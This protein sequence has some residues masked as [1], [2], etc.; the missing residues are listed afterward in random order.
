VVAAPRHWRLALA[1]LSMTRALRAAPTPDETAVSTAQPTTLDGGRDV[2]GPVGERERQAEARRLRAL[3]FWDLRS[4]P[5]AK[6]ELLAAYELSPRPL[7]L[8]NLAVTS[9]ALGD[10]AGAYEYFES[11]L[12]QGGDSITAERR[13]MVERQLQDLAE[14]V[15]ALHVSAD[16]VGAQVLLDDKLVGTTPLRRALRLNVGDHSVTVRRGASSQETLRISVRGGQALPLH[17]ALLAREQHRA[18][19]TKR[20]RWLIASWTGTALLG[21]GAALAGW[22]A[23]VAN[24]DY[25]K[26][27]RELD[28]SRKQ[29]DEMDAK[30]LRWSIAADA[31]A[32]GALAAGACSLYLTFNRQAP[33]ATRRDVRQKTS[34]QKL[35]IA[36][37][38]RA[39]YVTGSF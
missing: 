33:D 30:A 32:V 6:E 31:L 38:P 5:A 7:F 39:A 17:F 1:L 35:S 23:L 37:S 3:R 20:T 21:T 13:A 11:Y 28:N 14:H 34:E 4:F 36:I 12:R 22:K 24:N 25:Q 16:V 10:S 19:E 29:F 8:Y 2:R 18:A 27:F 9:M 26:A 15:A